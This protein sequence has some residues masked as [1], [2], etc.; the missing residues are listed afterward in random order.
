[1]LF[2]GEVRDHACRKMK[3]KNQQ[4]SPMVPRKL[5]QKPKE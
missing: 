4:Q 2:D 5:K 1:M 3:E